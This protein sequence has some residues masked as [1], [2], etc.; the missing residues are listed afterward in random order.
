MSSRVVGRG[1]SGPVSLLSQGLGGGFI[2]GG[3]GIISFA[4]GAATGSAS[5]P[6]GR[7]VLSRTSWRAPSDVR[8]ARRAGRY[9]QSVLVVQN[10]SA[11]GP[12]RVGNWLREAGLRL[13]VVRACTGEPLPASLGSRALIVL[14]GDFLPDE[15]ERAPWSG[16]VGLTVGPAVLSDDGSRGAGGSLFGCRKGLLVRA[17]DALLEEERQPVGG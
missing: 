15:D 16:S 2:D 5:L 17:E 11:G 12:G 10:R 14:G 4:T 3:R 13:E 7:Q 6:D 1:N 9:G 8:P